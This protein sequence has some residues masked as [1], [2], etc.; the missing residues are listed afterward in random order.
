MTCMPCGHP[1]DYCLSTFIAAKKLVDFKQSDLTA[2]Q[3]N[4]RLDEEVMV[5]K[6]MIENLEMKLKK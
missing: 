4:D 6:G 2:Q 1:D 3:V 5:L